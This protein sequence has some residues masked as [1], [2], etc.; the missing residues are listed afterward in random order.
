MRRAAGAPT[1][2]PRTFADVLLKQGG[3]QAPFDLGSR[4]ETSLY[5]ARQTDEREIGSS[6]T[7]SGRL[8]A[9]THTH[10]SNNTRLVDL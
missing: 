2:L 5:R 6:A 8:N 7:S 10:T 1:R 3:N 4:P 9:D